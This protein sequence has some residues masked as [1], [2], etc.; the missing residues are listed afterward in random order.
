LWVALAHVWALALSPL[1]GTARAT[2]LLSAVCTALACAAT[3]RLVARR[4]PRDGGWVGTIGGVTMGTMLS[5]WANATETEVYAFALLHSAAILLAAA[6]C[7]E[8]EGRRADRWLLLAAY[9]I[10]LAPASHLSVLVAAPAAI[11]LAARR[12]GD[13]RGRAA[14]RADRALVLAGAMLAA[15][16]VGRMQWPIVAIG[17]AVVLATMLVRERDAGGRVAAGTFALGTLAFSALLVL[18]V[19]A[20]FDPSI[21][22]GEPTTLRA[23]ADVVARRQYDVA[24]LL[25]RR[26]PVW[27]QLAN[28]LQYADWQVAM[29]WGTGVLTSPA[30][31]AATL[32]WLALGGMGVRAL[33]RDARTLCIALVVLAACGTIGVGAYLNLKA[34]A[35]LGWGILP[36]GAPHEARERDYFFVPGYWA[37]AC[38]AGAGAVALARRWRLPPAAA[39]LALV[40]PLAGNWRAADRARGPESTAARRFGLALLEAAP[41]RA[42]LFVDG[43]N[44]SYPIWYLQTV[45]RV[46]PDV[47]PVTVPLLPA[48]WYAR[49][50]SRR[51][52]L[53][54]TEEPVPGAGTLSAQRAA[55]IA[56]AAA[57][58]GRPV[59]ASPALPAS[60]R[61]LLGADWVLRG[62]VYVASGPGPGDRHARVDTV[63]A[64]AWAR[65]GPS[66]PAEGRSASGDD[67]ARVMLRLLDCPAELVRTQ[68][69]A[70]RRDSLEVKC[71]LR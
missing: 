15:A 3:A 57:A 45:E 37:W 56:K 62:P 71:N 50:V 4:V 8:E 60:E 43:D 19:R 47:V 24:P 13:V 7:G 29:G 44:D 27:L 35:S 51:N 41:R 20:R 5:V 49:Q 30:R 53:R 23:L 26:A 63:T 36:D 14:W 65:R 22:Q 42:V 21:D 2:N 48:E 16:G 52:G 70:A 58:E 11:V 68:P 32:A 28:V 34:G 54:W 6:R 61:A 9:L 33:R 55:L 18:L 59:A 46:R 1:L 31:V 17:G 12:T 25:P 66:W 40:V 10:A 69:S 67:V 38:L 64:A 39:A